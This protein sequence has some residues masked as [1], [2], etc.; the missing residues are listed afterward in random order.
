MSRL[1]S[2]LYGVTRTTGKAASKTRDAEVILSGSPSKIAK[3]FISKAVYKHMG[4][5]AKKITNM[6]K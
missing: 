1:S 5:T 2:F 3:R 6:M 4:K